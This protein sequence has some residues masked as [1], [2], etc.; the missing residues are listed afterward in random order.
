MYAE[1]YRRLITK[2]NDIAPT[3]ESRRMRHTIHLLSPG[4]SLLIWP[5]RHRE[6]VSFT[7][8]P[9]QADA[10]GRSKRD[11]IWQLCFV[12]QWMKQFN[13]WIDYAN[14]ENRS[15]ELE[16][17]SAFDPFKSYPT[18]VRKQFFKES[19]R[20]FEYSL[21]F[22]RSH[23]PENIAYPPYVRSISK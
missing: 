11:D 14:R 22:F 18:S 8:L 10:C 23:R 6:E 4:G 20:P 12:N 2:Q 16:R 13:C 15:S 17:L 19:Q 5:S 1:W 3:S 9:S 21:D 7:I